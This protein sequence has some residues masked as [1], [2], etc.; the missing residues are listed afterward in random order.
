MTAREAIENFRES[1]P[2]PLGE[3]T[4]TAWLEELEGKIFL[5]IVSTHEG[6]RGEF[7]FSDDSELAAAEPYSALYAAY[8]RMK[9]DLEF[10]DTVRYQSSAPVFAAAWADFANAYNRAHRPLCRA[11]LK[12]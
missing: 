8:L 10:S 9:C 3:D 2:S 7:S 11:E 12:A 1:Y 5:E 6:G 4:L